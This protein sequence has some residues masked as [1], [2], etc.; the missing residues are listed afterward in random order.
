MNPA[1][2]YSLITALAAFIFAAGMMVERW[3]ENSSKLAVE[4]VVQAVNEI[5]AQQ[6]AAITIENKTIFN[7]TV[8]HMRTETVYSECKMDETTLALI[9]KALTGK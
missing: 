5:K 4:R 8:E 3:K 9:N 2:K 6:I 1:L 7:K